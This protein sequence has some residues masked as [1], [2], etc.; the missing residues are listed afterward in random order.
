M[1][2]A[3]GYGF[4]APAGVGCDLLILLFSTLLIGFVGAPLIVWTLVGAAFL[5]G[6]AA[7]L[8]CL[9]VFLG[10][11]VIFNL[12]PLRALFFSGPILSLLKKANMLPAISETERVALEAGSIWVDGEL[13]SGRPNFKKILSEPYPELTHEEKSF[14]E[15]PVR[16]LCNQV[17]D[18]SIFQ[19]KDLPPEVWKFLKDEKF[20][21][22]I[23]PKEYGGLGFSA[24]LHSEVIAILASRSG[25]L[26]VST[27][28]PNSL[29]PAELLIHYGTKGQK[30]YYLPRLAR[31]EEIP[32]FAL[33][34][35]HAGSDAGGIR[36]TAVVFKGLDGK[37]YLRLNWNKRYCTLAAVS[38]I[39]GLAVQM[40]DPE[41]LLGHGVAPGITCVL[42][43]SNTP[44]V[45][46]GRRHDP[47]GVPFF[48]CPT[49]GKDV[50]VS[51]EQIIGGAEGAG[52]GWEMLMAC[53]A[54]GRS[55]SLPA[56]ATGQSKLVT[57]VTSAYCVVRRQFG[58]PIG[59]FEGIEEP[60]ARIASTTYLVDAMR[61]FTTGAVDSGMKPAVI[62]AI[63]KYNAT[64]MVRKVIND[65]LDILG[66]AGIS[67]GPRNLLAHPYMSTPIGITVEGANI[68]TR[69]LMIFG[70]GAI[71]CHPYA[72]KE[73]KALSD[74]DVK[75]F[76]ALFTSHLGFVVRNKCRMILLS[77]TRGRLAAVPS[78]PLA[79]YCRKLSWSSATFAFLTDVALGTF[80]GS[81]K[82]RE[83][84]TGRFADI[85]S[86][87][88]L[89]L[90]AIRRFEAEGRKKEHLPLVTHALET[91]F[92][93][94]QAGFDGLFANFDVPLI[95]WIF[96]GPVALIS[97]FNSM[98]KPPRDSLGHEVVKL[99]EVPGATRDELTKGMYLPDA[100]AD[101]TKEAL[102][103]L[104]NGFR[105]AVQS[106]E[107]LLKVRKAVKKK[108]LPKLQ[109]T[110]LILAAVKANVISEEEAKLLEAAEAAQEDV[111]QVDSFKLEEFI[112]GAAKSGRG[113]E[114]TSAASRA[115]GQTV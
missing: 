68:L 82:M 115:W 16:T 109:G 77:C 5:Y 113:Q 14:I 69:T 7:P 48:N 38:T 24:R 73:I 95:G 60:L 11:S 9:G 1:L 52:R 101:V 97:R 53:L 56:Q 46:L 111:I 23:I 21:G 84:V 72:Y 57:R 86:W 44:G 110:E 85:L 15:G 43:P 59:K 81:L 96:R 65:G 100:Q 45:V 104:E 25:P 39:I 92:A 90:S 27:M 36:S 51:I 37:A 114:T 4:L 49:E 26:A 32:C 102:A 76:D 108:T 12:P 31:G 54:A 67:R 61:T 58:V 2:S 66:G 33:T 55:I 47:M 106:G 107:I 98:G 50:V 112:S 103:R 29:G 83:K 89:A 93:N 22:L 99:I 70:Q 64:E 91:C 17:D 42:V 78:T 105:L 18:W 3:Y 35:P 80:G 6:I 8:W 74:G 63:A 62:S 87:M 71:R 19:N 41:N 13:F 40:K 88:Y 79:K 28:V 75:T 10:L 94:I 20:F 30:D 34:E